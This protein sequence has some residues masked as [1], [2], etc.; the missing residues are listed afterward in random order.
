MRSVPTRRIAGFV[1]RF[2]LVYAALT[3]AWPLARPVYR[4]LFC[5]LG[6]TLFGSVHGGDGAVEFRPQDTREELDVEVVLTKHGPP[7]VRARAENKSRVVGYLPTI[8]LIAFVLATPI[9]W[10]RRRRALLLGLLLVTLFVAL[11]MGIPLV[12]DFSR[13]DALRVY[14]LGSLSR[15]ILGIGERALLAAPASSFVVPVLIWV[16]VA[17]RRQDW[18][19]L[20]EPAADPAAPAE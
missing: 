10:K 5:A 6:N 1:L 18:E 4:S 20:A 16:L 14:E 19:L 8:S 2:A 15:R 17:F 9:P 7:P 12:R 11:R 3:L 13:S